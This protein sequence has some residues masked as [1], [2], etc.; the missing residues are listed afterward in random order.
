MVKSI[1][2]TPV[3]QTPIIQSPFNKQRKDKFLLVL[4]VPEILKDDINKLGKK[5]G[6]IN[7][8]SLQFSVYGAVVPALVVP[9]VSLSYAGQTTKITSYARP[10]CPCLVVNFTVDNMFNNYFVIYKWL[11][12]L[13]NE[14]K[15][16][17]NVDKPGDEGKLHRY[18]TNVTIYGLDE[19]NNKVARFNYLK[20]FPVRLDGI[21]YSERDPSEMQSTFEFGYSQ[22]TMELL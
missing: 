2:Q 12:I 20:A 5:Y 6:M 10:E 21:T 8:D 19:Y 16:Y 22:W 9:S 18:Q 4:T 7:F 11:D 13:N 17:Y 14:T 3:N 15:S 1:D